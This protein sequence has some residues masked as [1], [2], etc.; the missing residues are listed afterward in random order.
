MMSWDYL[1]KL[2]NIF[3]HNIIS[4]VLKTLFTQRRFTSIIMWIYTNWT[5]DETDF[6]IES[7]IYEYHII[8]SFRGY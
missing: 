7:R 8:K 4:T 2:Y 5:K 1:T 3:S 6:Q